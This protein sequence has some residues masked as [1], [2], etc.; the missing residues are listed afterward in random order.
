ME[1]K[2]IIGLIRERYEL[3]K[4]KKDELWEK[5]VSGQDANA[6]LMCHMAMGQ[7]VLCETLLVQIGAMEDG[8]AK[9]RKR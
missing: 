4:K 3:A 7:E 6:T 2:Q 8:Q 1:S 5:A 9:Q